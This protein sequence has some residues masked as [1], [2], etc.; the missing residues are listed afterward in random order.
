MGCMGSKEA[1]GGQPK[2]VTVGAASGITAGRTPSKDAGDTSTKEKE[3]EIE[4]D[5]HLEALANN[6]DFVQTVMQSSFVS[7]NA[8]LREQFDLALVRSLDTYTSSPA[9]D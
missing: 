7:E 5:P 6:M 8:S 2:K 4:L 9:L 3:P 1:P